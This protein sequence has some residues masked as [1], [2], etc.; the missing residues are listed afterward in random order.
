MIYLLI[1]CW[2]SLSSRP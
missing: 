1:A 2:E